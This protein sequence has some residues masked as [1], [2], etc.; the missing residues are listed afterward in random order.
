[1]ISLNR[2]DIDYLLRQVTINY[3]DADGNPAAFN[4][5][6]LRN[7]LDPSGIREVAGSNNNLVGHGDLPGTPAANGT[8]GPNS[9]WGQSEQPFLRLSQPTYTGQDAAYGTDA[10]GNGTGAVGTNVTDGSVRIVSELVSTMYTTGADANP[11]AIDAATNA[12]P[13]AAN[14]D[15]DIGFVANAGVLGGGRYNSWFVAF[16][17]F[18]DHGLDFISKGGNGTITIPIAENDPLYVSA[19]LE[20]GSAN[21]AFIPGVSNVMRI[22][23]AT[24]ANP[25]SD[26]DNGALKPD[27][28]PVYAN[29]TGPLIDQSQTYGSHASTNAFLREYTADGTLTGRLVAATTSAGPEGSSGVATWA[30]VKINAERIFIDLENSD[31]TAVPMLRVDPAG[32]LLFTPGANPDRA[33]GLWSTAAIANYDPAAQD[34][35][36]PFVRDANG[37]VVKT[38]QA[39]LLD[40]NPDADP[41]FLFDAAGAGFDAAL[42]D[43]HYVAGD[44]RANENFALTSIHHVFHEEH[45]TQVQNIKDTIVREAQSI[46]ATE[47]QTAAD[48]FVAAW[49][50]A[51]GV[52]DGEKLFQ[53]ARLITETEYNHVAVDQYVGTLYGALPEFVSYSADINMSV[54]LEF[55][56]AVF[57]LGHSML[58]ETIDIV[59]AAGTTTAKIPLM[60]AFLQP[61]LYAQYGPQAI[62]R[63]LV[64]QLGNEVDEFVTPALQQS[65]LGQPLDLAA[66]NLARGRDIGLPTWNELRQQVYDGLIQ[67]TSTNTNGSALAPYTSWTDVGNHLRNEGTLLNLIAAY[68]HDDGGTFGLADA[69]ATGDVALMREAAGDLLAAYTDTTDANHAAAVAFMDGAPTY[70]EATGTWSFTS[71]D[72]GYWDID[73]WIGG[74]AE[75]PLFDGPLGTTFSFVILDFAQRM[76]DGD[77]FYY[78]YRLPPGTHLGDQIIAEQFAD[79]V[80]RTTGIEHLN[81]DV[82][83]RADGTF[84]ADNSIKTGGVG[85]LTGGNDFFDVATKTITAVD[86]TPEKASNLHNII[87]GGDGNDYLKGGLGDDTLYGDAGNDYLEGSQGNDHLYGGDGDDTIHD[88]END[89]FIHGGAG[90]DRIFAGGGVLD[91]IHGGLG[92]D[93][94]H[95]GDGI[96]EV[97]GSEGDDLL[98]GEGDT[99]LMLGEDGNDYLE[100][101]D[102]VDEMFGG[103]GNDWLRGGVG[104]DGLQGESGNDLME[105]GL[106]PAANDGDRLVGGT[107][108]VGTEVGAAIGDGFDIASYEDVG[109]AITANLQTSNEN[110]TGALVDT[111]AFVDGLVGTRFDDTLV[112]ADAATVTTNGADN[113]LVGGAGS[114]ILEGLGGDDQI[115]GDSVLVTNDL[116]AVLDPTSVG[117]TMISNWRGTGEDRPDFGVSGGLGHVLGDTGTGGIDTAVFTGEVSDYTITKLDATTVR[118]VDTRGIDSSVVGDLVKD[119]EQFRFSNGSGGSV[120][121]SF[122]QLTNARPTDIVWS[123]V[124]PGDTELPAAGDVL[125]RLGAFDPDAGDTHTFALLPGSSSG[126]DIAADGTVTRTGSALASNTT[127]T[128]LVRATDAAGATFDETL[129]IRTNGTGNSNLTKFATAGDDIQYGYLGNDTLT[130]RA[131]ADTLF[132]QAGNDRIIASV[133][134]GDDTYDGGAGADTYDLSATSAAA[135]VDL[136]AG[137]ASSAETGNDRL[138]G[139]E[140]VRGSQ[141]NNT[142]SGDAGSNAIDGLGGD[143]V[144]D[145]G[146]GADTITLGGGADA[147]IAVNDNAA[148]TVRGGAGVDTADYSVFN[149]GL[150]VT[151]N[152]AGSATVDGSGTTGNS[153]TLWSVE[154]FLSGS[155]DDRIVGDGAVNTI[156]GGAG[157]DFI[158]G[159]GNDDRVE[160]G[161][162]T[163][164]VSVRL[165]NDTIV[166]GPG[167]GSDFVLSFDSNAAGGQDKIDVSGTG[168]DA[169]ADLT[170]TD[171]A[172]GAVIEAGDSEVTLVGVDAATITESDFVFFIR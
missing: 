147:F 69:R 28:T 99:D 158:D 64:G 10:N 113:M 26:F 157:T 142:I 166:I 93:E 96:D 122:A 47:G 57:R 19:L 131:G 153:D 133:G 140:N 89:D 88:D 51:P 77:R 72:R 52:W 139:I 25:D 46:V 18:F 40:I 76:Q 160:G 135:A 17:Q 87:A 165:G 24:L 56:Q 16:G 79:I 59:D 172:F 154:R 136:A 111:Y 2:T 92:D 119:V 53:A 66:I 34:P 171:T 118:L 115:F 67:N 58:T 27:V 164:I 38:G 155:G 78:L 124:T 105:G 22:S 12:D 35:H 97:F 11:A 86:G 128:L 162:G 65:L 110:G 126:F 132:G 74:L 159:R 149:T 94:V 108:A 91:T 138:A 100:G 70:D 148:D 106:G 112:G 39:F 14:Y 95:G 21:P 3:L 7:A 98:Y 102:S 127:Y 71:G 129:T 50:S 120:T 134:D 30:D 31:V 169:Y 82:F 32:K 84:L 137:T 121:V 23:R 75:R 60:D 1:M 107:I 168:L 33:D 125:G 170:I 4:Y 167:S 15:P 130:G 103:N 20:D 68:G 156:V 44:G 61:E 117:Y 90:N 114:D 36:D 48:A 145:G 8:P 43:A 141:G 83:I 29:S 150:S 63:G 5:S 42:L 73:L 144:V 9:M 123:G 81:G 151:L 80:T 116:S 45:N 161:A 37:A 104:D 54:S 41:T 62:T 163:D 13:N 55:S 6:Q 85:V 109:I 143:D 49:Q 146:A 101:G 152:A